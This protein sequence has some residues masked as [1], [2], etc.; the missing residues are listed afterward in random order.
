MISIRNYIGGALVTKSGARIDLEEPATGQLAGSLPDST[1]GDVEKAVQAAARAYPDWVAMGPEGRSKWLFKLADAIEERNEAFALAES[2]DSGKPLS[3]ALS[4]DIPRAISNFRYF[5]GA[6]LHDSSEA[7]V[8]RPSVLNYTLRQPLGVVGCISPWNLPLYLFSWKIAPALAAGN[9]V[10][11]KPSEITPLTAFMLSEVCVEIGFP[12]GVLN[13]LHGRGAGVGSAIVNHPEVKAISFTGGTATGRIIARAA[14]ESFKKVSLELGGKNPTI[15]FE[16][17]NLDEAVDGALRAAFSNQGQICLCGS[18]I[19]VHSSVYKEVR[20]RLIEKTSALVIG[21]PLDA[22][23][24]VG[25][26]VSKEHLAKV[27][28]MVEQAISE[29]GRVLVGG[30]TVLVQGRCASGYFMEPTLIE[31]LDETCRT[32]QDEIFGPVATL[33]PF[34]DESEAIRIANATKYGLAA[35]VW[36]NDIHRATRVSEALHSGI[37]WVNCWMLR[38]LR[39]PF[40]GVN[41]SGMGRE[42]GTYA[43]R[44]FTEAK[45]VCV[46]TLPR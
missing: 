36:T 2:R 28:G 33:I 41:D 13:I 25:S 40:G 3:V 38:D 39:T 42:G 15:I 5:A 23:T 4:V 26:L 8:D 43:L 10:I 45:N 7:Y 18:R 31:G 12:A 30:K 46:K 19:L 1:P 35:S 11:G 16:D 34:S 29:G 22:A 6:I 27:L 24:Q 20:R 9:C 37:V 32:N 44:F 17:A 14:A 21:D